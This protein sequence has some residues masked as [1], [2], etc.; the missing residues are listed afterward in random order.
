MT[1]YGSRIARLAGTPVLGFTL[2]ARYR[3][4]A[5]DKRITPTPNWARGDWMEPGPRE[6]RDAFADELDARADQLALALLARE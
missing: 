1:V 6:R 5:A 4:T 3:R 2:I